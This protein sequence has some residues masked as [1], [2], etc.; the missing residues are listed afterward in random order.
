MKQTYFISMVYFVYMQ[1][2]LEEAEN[3]V[4]Q[5]WDSYGEVEL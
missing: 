3:Q 2:C 1:G 4:R 5:F